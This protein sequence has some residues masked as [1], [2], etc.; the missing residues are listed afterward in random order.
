MHGSSTTA[1]PRGTPSRR[2]KSPK[3]STTPSPAQ[4]SSVTFQSEATSVSTNS[5]FSCTSIPVEGAVPIGNVSSP[6]KSPTLDLE[7]TP[8]TS[9]N[10]R[11]PRKSKT[12]AL[13]ALNSH[14]RDDIVDVDET[15]S[16][17]ALEEKY[18]QSAAIPVTPAL[19]LSTV[20][21]TSPRHFSHPRSIQRPF[22][23]QDCPEYFPTK[24]EF[25]DPMAY[26]KSI[27]AEAKEY[28]ICKIVP[29][30]DWKMPF[31]QDTEKFRFKT[32]LQR[33]N[34]IEA[35]SRAKLNFLEQLY[36]FHKQ[37]GIPRVAIPTIN[38][39]PLDLWL[40]RKEVHKLGGYDAVNRGKK[41]TEVA[42]TLGYT[43]VPGLYAQLKNSYARVILPYESFCERGRNTPVSPPH[44]SATKLPIHI[45]TPDK[46]SH[47]NAT[48]T[49][50]GE[51]DST[52]SSPL[53][54]S[55]SPLSE[56]PDE[57]EVREQGSRPRRNA[58]P[59]S[60][61][62]T[63]QSLKKLLSTP[64]LLLPLPEPQYH[65][66][67]PVIKQGQAGN[68]Y[69]EICG[70]TNRA[71]KM[72]L[73]DGCEGGFHMFCLDPPLDSVPKSNWYCYSCLSGT[74][75]D[76]GFDEGEEHSLSSFQARDTEFRRMWFKS[77]PP[78]PQPSAMK[79]DP[80]ALHFGDITVSEYDIENEFWRL[81][82]SPN[83][84]VE[85]EYG[86][87]IHSTTHGSAMPTLETHPLDKYSKDP[88]NLNNIPVVSD[89]LLRY[90][91]SDISGMTVPWTYVGMTFSTFCW[92][93]EDHYTYSVNFMHW[94][95]TKTWYGIPG[96]DAEKFETA[97]RYE[98][99]DLFATQPDLLFQLV[100]LMNP[101][102]LTD[103][104][105]R[106]YACNQRAG[107][108]VV[109]FPQ[110]YHAGFNHGFNFNEA[111][112]F[113]LPDWLP[114]GRECVERYR[115]FRKL[116]VFSHDELLITITQQST[117]IKTAM[118]LTD[119]LREMTEREM[120]NRNKARALGCVDSLEEQDRP[121]D[122]YQCAVCKVFCYLSQICCS[123][124]PKVACAD[125]A[126]LLCGTCNASNS[127]TLRTRFSDNELLE[128]QSKVAERAAIPAAWQLKLDKLLMESARPSLRHLRSLLTE[129]ERIHIHYPLQEISMLRKCVTRANEWIECA[130]A[131]TTRKQSRKRPRRS[132]GRSAQDMDEATE[133]P[134][135]SLNDLYE[136]LREVDTLGFDCPEIG[137]L[138][139]LAQQA[140]E[141]KSAGT[142]ILQ[143]PTENRNREEY[144]QRCQK[145]VLDASSLN[146]LIDEVVEIEKI[147]D[148]EHLLVELEGKMVDGFTLTLEEV[149]QLL[150]RSQA[151]GLTSD[152]K[153]IHLLDTR[154]R[155]GTSWEDRAQEILQKPVKTLQ[156][157]DQF[158][159]LDPSV[160]IDPTVLDRIMSAR[161][162]ARDFEKTAKNWLEAGATKPR[163]GDVIKLAKRAEKEF[164]L[165]VLQEVKSMAQIANELEDRSEQI[166]KSTYPRG[167][168]EDVFRTIEEWKNYAIQH[169]KIFSLPKFEKVEMQVAAHE[170]W[171]ADL[172]WYCRKHNG[173]YVHGKEV[174]EDVIACTRP[175]DDQPPNDEYLTCICNVPVRPP[176]PGVPS[177]AVQCDH[178][179]ARFHE[180]CAKNGGSCP[181][182]DHSHWTGDIAKARS[183][184]FCF[185][186]NLLINAPE[187]SK[188]YSEEWKQLEV[189]VHRVDRLSVAI[190]QFLAYT[191]Q[192]A[193][194]HPTYI[195]Q[196][197]HY[198]RKLYKIQFAVSPNPKVSFGLDLAGLHRI[199]ASRP[200]KR[201]KPKFH[202]GQDSDAD[203]EDGTRCICRGRTSYLLGYATVTCVRCTRRYHAGCVFYDE[204]LPVYGSQS[205][206]M[207]ALCCLRKNRTYPYSEVRVKPPP[208]DIA[209]AAYYVDIKAMMDTYSKTIIYKTM[210]PPE[211]RTL[212]VDLL[213]FTPGQ[214]DTHTGGAAPPPPPSS[215]RTPSMD[216][217]GHHPAPTT[218]APVAAPPP[219]PPSVLNPAVQNVPPP[220]WSRWSTVATPS[221]PPSISS[222]QRHELP[223]VIPLQEPQQQQDSRKRKH[224]ED[225]PHEGLLPPMS[226]LTEPVAKR[227]IVLPP[228]HHQT[229]LPPIQSHPPRA[230]QMPQTRTPVLPNTMPQNQSLSPSLARLMSPV[231][232]S[233]R[234]QYS[235]AHSSNV[236]GPRH[237]NRHES[238]LMRPGGVDILNSP[239]MRGLERDVPRSIRG[240]D[241]STVVHPS[242]SRN[243]HVPPL[244]DRDLRDAAPSSIVNGRHKLL[245]SPLIEREGPRGGSNGHDKGRRSPIMR[246]T[247]GYSN[248]MQVSLAT[249]IDAPPIRKLMMS[250]GKP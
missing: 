249:G 108:F 26:I 150:A 178:C 243:G 90:I 73:C 98:A 208:T 18:R 77:H 149:R 5:F 204:K 132:K 167:A 99:P 231:D 130:N 43:N 182:C 25:E 72:L 146:V 139:N 135:K 1:S 109:T 241:P 169:L 74:G 120:A 105:V 6:D 42:R 15:T 155:E 27:S 173:A 81:V 44:S 161:D 138:R 220:P 93:N 50:I 133:K 38:H 40:L 55:S 170:K 111:V 121:E 164:D 54:A 157:L 250:P 129:G 58:K 29:P 92:H 188:K 152:N 78:P 154:L 97:I 12:F 239:P 63:T 236:V 186:P 67:E 20:K 165:P 28:G 166:L 156:D 86:A 219:I 117:T 212:F 137:T 128:I 227:R 228:V 179:Y 30:E 211:T 222:R 107:E 116:P 100:T 71:D 187:I 19:D 202:F 4:S 85:T 102:R 53:T 224:P 48:S 142:A 230:P 14:V 80:T 37:Q 124:Q 240:N 221:R 206:Y 59:V 95:E 47:S 172:P 171:V 56:P 125:H 246:G 88:W 168:N 16:L 62:Q 106:V 70:K 21:T 199:L 35:S 183:W 51:D 118:W 209:H 237:D 189:I 195:H 225:F 163:P 24:E 192:P 196:V 194:Q 39:K 2:G 60:V 242:S 144:M 68:E 113:A 83:E 214:P 46:E 7:A 57:S 229:P 96:A 160:P 215:S 112:N 248:N 140:E 94:G 31:V 216:G 11:A 84:T 126:Y 235:Y 185:F 247:N 175:E 141:L 200:K 114:Y 65:D 9:E 234:S 180:E 123:H 158:A 143:T 245:P 82:Q 218:Y 10:K 134:E 226:S 176:P 223:P 76:Y 181:F 64:E 232:Q 17:S 3:S 32:R 104:G 52:A 238:P 207:C 213:S 184:H 89:S 148:K 136:L 91:K 33:L 69:C 174:L 36:R 122:Q 34:S 103:V 41:W 49:N 8:S 13:A 23:L 151:C 198:M 159:D 147:V 190:G 153:Y 110:A 177:D 79:N 61:D 193:N 210:G 244:I 22:G 201:R 66:R 75:G 145:L 217:I 131:F 127:L 203:W 205:G 191:S 197:R 101:K 115:A 87:D 119:S 233:P 45:Q 162:K